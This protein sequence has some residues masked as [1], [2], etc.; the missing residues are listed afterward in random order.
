MRKT[1][2]LIDNGVGS[3]SYTFYVLIKKE[4]IVEYS[5]RQTYIS[6]KF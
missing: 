1:T 5:V 3:N 2:E 4:L 6:N